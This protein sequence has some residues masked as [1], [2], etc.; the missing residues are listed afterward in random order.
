MKEIFCKKCGKRFAVAELGRMKVSKAEAETLCGT[1]WW[2]TAKPWEK[3]NL[4]QKTMRLGKKNRLKRKEART[5]ANWL[6]EA[7]IEDLQAT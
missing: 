5:E 4:K 6:I 7:N 3:Y 2:E 1:C